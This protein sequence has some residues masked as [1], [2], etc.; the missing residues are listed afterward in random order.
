M[1]ANAGART[2]SIVPYSTL[3]DSLALTTKEVAVRAIAE[4]FSGKR[5]RYLNSTSAF[6][7]K[8][9]KARQVNLSGLCLEMLGD[10][11]YV[12]QVHSTECRYS[13]K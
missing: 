7:L 10:V 3:K 1:L 6:M 11:I 8:K 4:I 13:Y 2:Q 12:R 9:E 5:Y